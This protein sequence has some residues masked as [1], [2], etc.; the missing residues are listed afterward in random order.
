[1]SLAKLTSPLLHDLTSSLS[2][3]STRIATAIVAAVAVFA[4]VAA[5]I[6]IPNGVIAL[7]DLAI[8]GIVA[9]CALRLS[10]DANAKRVTV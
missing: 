7:L 1:M 9:T 2:V 8:F 3:K 5:V 4:L 6:N 10:S